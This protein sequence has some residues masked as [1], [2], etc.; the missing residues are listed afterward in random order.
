MV[1]VDGEERARW[2]LCGRNTCFTQQIVGGGT[3][4]VSRQKDRAPG[5]WCFNCTSYSFPRYMT[6]S[7]ERKYI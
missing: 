5:E 3:N 7:G 4:P 1:W 2:A 6:S